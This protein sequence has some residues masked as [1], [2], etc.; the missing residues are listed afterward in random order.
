[1]TQEEKLLIVHG[2]LGRTI[3][4][5]RPDE[6]RNGAGF[7]PGVARLGIPEL[8][9]TD[10]SLGVVNAK[11]RRKGDVATAMPSTLATAASFDTALAYRG[12]AMIGAE[13]RAKGYNVMLAG[14]ANLVRDPWAGRNFEYFSEDV[15][16]TGAM[17]GSAIAG[18]QSNR[19]V[20]TLKHYVLNAQETGRTVMNATI[21]EGALRDSD[22]LAFRIALEVGQP[23]SVMCG[24]NKVNGDYNCESR[25]L[26]TD[27]LK[28]DWGYSGWVMSDWGAVHSTVKSANAGLDQESGE[29]L[30]AQ[31]YFA[32]PLA[33]AV[34]SG[35]VAQ[36]RLDDMVLRILRSLIATGVLDD[37]AP[38]TPQSIDYAAN[39]VVALE[40]AEKGIVL[41][42]NRDNMLP[43]AAGARRILVVGGHADKGVLS[44]GGSSQVRSAA[45]PDLE[46]PLPTENPLSAFTGI[47]Y[48]PSSP[49]D[50]IRKLAPDAQVSFMDGADPQ[51]AA[52][53][54][55]SADFVVVFA[56]QWRSEALDL[57]T[58]ALPDGQDELIAGVAA[59]NP[60]TAVVLETGGAVEMPWL[61]D[62][63]AVLAAW[64]PGQRGGE[65]IARVLFGLANPSGRLPISFPASMSDAPRPA[66]PGL[67]MVNEARERAKKSGIMD[68]AGIANA[69]PSFDVPYAEGADVGYR[70]YARESRQPLF[71]FGF[72]LSYTSFEYQALRIERAEKPI[73]HVTVT[74]AGARSGTDV[75]QIYAN[76]ALQGGA[77]LP[78]LVGFGRVDLAAGESKS[79]SI[80]LD[81]RLMASF[82]AASGQWSTPDGPVEVTVSRDAMTPIMKTRLHL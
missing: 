78:R 67:N 19:I 49:L 44:G 45:G 23:G 7:V 29:E 34:R 15:L 53:A 6:W 39:S 62:V 82:D 1:M 63:G 25:H 42:R 75:V 76:V 10:A 61:G 43:L 73:A 12:G 16:L 71:P 58:L 17:A 74:N 21:D 66:P 51:A 8:F 24:Y 57:D 28:N 52:D 33:E 69:V 68:P 72:G 64:Y 5:T 38:S 20:S 70:W 37:P 31:P 47:S 46:I 35:K 14:G 36:Q 32:A 9:E 56:H 59:A 4:K 3:L 81:L 55:R 40:A 30:D 60:D 18:V 27:V 79:I 54:A 50:E 41:L 22:L 65:A 26:L 11:N 2:Q 80:P 13:A 48:H 77:I